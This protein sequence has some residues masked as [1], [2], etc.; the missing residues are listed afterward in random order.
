MTFQGFPDRMGTQAD[1]FALT[2][3]FETLDTGNTH[4]K[5]AVSFDL[6]A[7]CKQDAVYYPGHIVMINKWV[8]LYFNSA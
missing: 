8:H 5:R 3:M 6:F 7:Y 4:L 1:F 2:A